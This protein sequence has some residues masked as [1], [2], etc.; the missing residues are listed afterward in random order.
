MN[1]RAAARATEWDCARLLIRFFN[2]FDAFRYDE[3]AAMFAPDGVWHRQGKALTG[4]DAIRAALRE[5][6]TTQTVRHVVTNIDVTVSGADRAEFLFYLTAYAHDAGAAPDGKPPVIAAPFLL[7]TVPGS[8]VRI[9][10]QWHI[11]DMTMDRTFVFR[12]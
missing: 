9:G 10:G 12:R 6:S 2:A 5:R 8:C 1:D 4:R 11:A 7:L 3:M